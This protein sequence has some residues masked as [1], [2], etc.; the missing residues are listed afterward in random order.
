[1]IMGNCSAMGAF[2][3]L[4]LCLAAWF[5]S[6][7]SWAEQRDCRLCDIAIAQASKS[8][9][10]GWVRA[11]QLLGG[12]RLW[13]FLPSLMN[14]VTCLVVVNGGDALSICLNTIAVL[15]LYDV[16]NM[17]FAHLLSDELR[18][19]VIRGGRV[20]LSAQE[21]HEMQI[22]RRT[23]TP[24]VVAGLLMAVLAAATVGN[25]FVPLPVNFLAVLVAAIAVET[26]IPARSARQRV[27]AMATATGK[28]V[29][30]CAA[31]MTLLGLA[32]LV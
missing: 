14:A 5:L 30:G 21:A 2:D 4:T 19:S 31:F 15:F 8:L 29:L 17:A 24:A 6:L 1:M 27:M 25:A 26:Q 11:L 9:S 20:L 13:V 10:P 18:C 22:V 12:I 16:D 7:A 23:S 32:N 3:I 28:M